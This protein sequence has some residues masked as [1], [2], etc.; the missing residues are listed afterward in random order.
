MA[1]LTTMVAAGFTVGP[2]TDAATVGQAVFAT[3]RHTVRCKTGIDVVSWLATMLG[4]GHNKLGWRVEG[5][6]QSVLQGKVEG[7]GHSVLQGKVEGKG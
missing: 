6:G 5:K 2:L 4:S 7:K 3:L 1:G